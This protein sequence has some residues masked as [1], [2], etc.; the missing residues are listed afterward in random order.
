MNGVLTRAS[1]EYAGC[2]AT[3]RSRKDVDV[4]TNDEE[5][6]RRDGGKSQEQAKYKEEIEASSTMDCHV[7]SAIIATCQTQH[8]NGSGKRSART[9]LSISIQ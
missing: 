9:C 3:L 2:I 7:S 8:V 5:D 4:A 6:K 1:A